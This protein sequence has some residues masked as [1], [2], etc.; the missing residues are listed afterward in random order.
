MTC[1]SRKRG[2]DDVARVEKR[3][4]GLQSGCWYQVQKGLS[5]IPPKFDRSSG[6]VRPLL[7]DRE[8]KF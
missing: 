3:R 2:P 8:V 5:V 7:D 6:G 4:D 1:V